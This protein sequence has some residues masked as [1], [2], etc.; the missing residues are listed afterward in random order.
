MRDRVDVQRCYYCDA[1][2]LFLHMYTYNSKAD[3]RVF[4]GFFQNILF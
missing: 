4:C 3:G 1:G 2:R